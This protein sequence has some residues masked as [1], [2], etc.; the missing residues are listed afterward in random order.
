MP[1]ADTIY[2]ATTLTLMTLSLTRV[3]WFD[4]EDNDITYLRKDGCH[5]FICQHFHHMSHARRR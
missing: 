4:V 1:V 3:L 5:S 2:D